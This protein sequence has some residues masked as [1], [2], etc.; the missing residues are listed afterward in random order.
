MCSKIIIY[1]SYNMCDS[2]DNTRNVNLKELLELL[3]AECVK[4]SL[5]KITDSWQYSEIQDAEK[6][7]KPLKMVE[8]SESAPQTPEKAAS[9]NP[10]SAIFSG[11]SSR[12]S[13]APTPTLSQDYSLADLDEQYGPLSPQDEAGKKRQRSE[14]KSRSP[15]PPS[16][17]RHLEFEKLG[18]MPTSRRS[19]SSRR[20]YDE[21]EEEVVEEDQQVMPELT[22][23]EAVEGDCTVLDM[24][25][26]CSAYGAAI[27]GVC[28]VVSSNDMPALA[29]LPGDAIASINKQI[30]IFITEIRLRLLK[31]DT[32]ELL[33]IFT[34]S[35][36]M[37]IGAYTTGT[38]VLSSVSMRLQNT[39]KKINEARKSFKSVPLYGGKRNKYL[40]KTKKVRKVRKNKKTS[41][42]L[43]RKKVLHRK[44]KN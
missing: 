3:D 2:S 16:T 11:L 5:P 27:M 22:V 44:K 41:K 13:S 9:Q 8:K 33:K 12:L 15:S 36:M 35:W 19:S 43:K 17:R 1:Y 25:I 42:S 24:F 20:R 39:C 26:A 7:L 28:Y 29:A 40:R 38:K 18:G 6:S 4:N 14:S 23:P 21:E 30:E 37:G 31:S 10:I 32:T 34:S